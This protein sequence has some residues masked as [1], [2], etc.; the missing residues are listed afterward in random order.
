M[1]VARVLLISTIEFKAKTLRSSE[2]VAK[3]Y[4][5]PND[6]VPAVGLV[7]QCDMTLVLRVWI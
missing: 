7:S 3:T 1:L 4:I 2:Q 5:S 6:D